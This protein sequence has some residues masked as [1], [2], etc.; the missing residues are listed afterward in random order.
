MAVLLAAE[1]GGRY[2]AQ[3]ASW[4]MLS[5]YMHDMSQRL[6][7]WRYDRSLLRAAFRWSLVAILR[8]H[9]CSSSTTLPATIL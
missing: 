3:G 5:T 8:S 2:S 6:T 4:C 1:S 9:A 7:C